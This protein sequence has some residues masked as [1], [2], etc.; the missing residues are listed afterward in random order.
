MDCDVILLHDKASLYCNCL[1]NE[2]TIETDVE[3]SFTITPARHL[4]SFP[5]NVAADLIIK[6]FIWGQNTIIRLLVGQG[7]K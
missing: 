7:E 4:W 1:F 3:L 5:H 6:S 2:F